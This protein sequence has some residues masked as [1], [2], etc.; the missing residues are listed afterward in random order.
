[1][2]VFAV[3]SFPVKMG[4]YGYLFNIRDKDGVVVRTIELGVFD[5]NFF[6]VSQPAPG[7]PHVFERTQLQAIYPGTFDDIPRGRGYTTTADYY[8]SSGRNFHDFV[9]PAEGM[10]G[11]IFGYQSVTIHGDVTSRLPALNAAMEQELAAYTF[12]VIEAKGSPA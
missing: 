2:G 6:V 7:H 3:V 11:V 8:H 4:E 5:L 10:A 1:V 12:E 9:K